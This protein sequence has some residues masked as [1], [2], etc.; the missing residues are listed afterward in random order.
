MIDPNLLVVDQP[1]P[2]K[3]E[4]HKIPEDWVPAGGQGFVQGLQTTMFQTGI[5]DWVS[6]ISLVE[7]EP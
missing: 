5:E 7:N 6:Q 3:I 2:V 4:R 1:E